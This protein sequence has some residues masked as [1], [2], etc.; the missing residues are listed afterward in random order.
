MNRE[1]TLDEL[2][3]RMGVFMKNRAVFPQEELLRYVNQWIAWSPDGTAIVAH[4]GE[5]E[6]LVYEQ[7]RAK[8]F[9]LGQCC[10][11]YVDDPNEAFFGAG[12]NFICGP[13]ASATGTDASPSNNRPKGHPILC[14]RNAVIVAAL[15]VVCF[16]GLLWVL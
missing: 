16:F 9:D 10:V 1:E 15:V 13:Q 3:A 2:A 14:T 8:G 11:S 4:S 6:A 7:L 12:L 5:S